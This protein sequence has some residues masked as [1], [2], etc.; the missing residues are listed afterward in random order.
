MAI[1]KRR[2]KARAVSPKKLV[3]PA[4]VEALLDASAHPLLDEIKQV[5]K[6][7]LAL[8]PAIQEEIKWNSASFRTRSDFFATV[9]LREKD[10]VQLVFFTGVKK[11]VT[12]VTG[13]PVEDPAGIVRKW[14]AKDRCLVGLGSGAAF[15]VNCKA[16]AAFVRAWIQFV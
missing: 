9:H 7:I 4:S 1:A 12:A 14:M 15:K 2:A 16:F 10:E 6:I 5:R 3:V 8:D 11:K 13:V